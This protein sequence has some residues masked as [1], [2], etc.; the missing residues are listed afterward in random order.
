MKVYVGGING[1]GKTTILKE[2]A[3]RLDFEYISTSKL[4]MEIIGRP[5]DYDHL[6]S[7]P[8]DQ[9]MEIREKMFDDLAFDSNR[10]LIVDSHYL[11]LIKGKTNI[12]TRDAIKKFDVF[13]LISAPI[14][15]VW[16]RVRKDEEIRDRALFPE[17]LSEED[18]F[19]MFKTY[20][21][22]TEREFLRLARLH[23]K[24]NIEIVNING[25]LESSVAKLVD[26]IKQC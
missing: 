8:S 11:N 23:Q 12:I 19:K 2:V 25:K 20:Q 26:F 9:Q 4:M 3:K 17:N 13:V 7:I 22:D 24:N 6:R 14:E 1:S 16:D 5:S 18:S 10:N 15:Q 21:Q